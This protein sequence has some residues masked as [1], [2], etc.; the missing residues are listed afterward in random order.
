VQTP[1]LLVL[2]AP[3]AGAPPLL[4]PMDQVRMLRVIP[5]PAA[6]RR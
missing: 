1:S 4:V 6:C 3:E 2:I 5:V